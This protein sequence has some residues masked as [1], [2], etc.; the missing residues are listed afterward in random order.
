MKTR[1]ITGNKSQI[2][3][4]KNK[5]WEVIYSAPEKIYDDAVAL[6][7]YM[8]DPDVPWYR[9]TV[10]IGCLVYLINPLDAIPDFTPIIG[11]ADDAALITLTINWLKGEIEDYY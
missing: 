2:K 11:F 3:T 8:L 6:Y 5:F 7:Y 4:V 10:A 9:K 1:L